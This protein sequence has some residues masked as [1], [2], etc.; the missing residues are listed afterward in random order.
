MGLRGKLVALFFIGFASTCSLGIAI[1]VRNLGSDFAAM[2]RNEAMRLND[3]LVRNFKAELEH[4]NE[5][6]TDWADWGGM[7]TFAQTLSPEFAADEVGTGALASAKL[8][9]VAIFDADHRRTFLR[10]A[11]GLADQESDKGLSRTLA[12]MQRLFETQGTTKT[13]SLHGADGEIYL[14]CWQYIHRSDGSGE[15]HGTLL[16]GRLL[17]E[18]ILRRMRNQS[19][20][21]FEI[22][23]VLPDADPARPGAAVGTVSAD[24]LV[25]GGP[26]KHMLTGRMLDAS[27]QPVFVFHIRLPS[28][29]ERSGRQITWRVILVVMIGALLSGV[30]L[31]LGV[32]YF[33]VRRLQLM[34]RQLRHVGAAGGWPEQIAT[35]PGGDEIATLGA[36]IN[37][38]LR[39]LREQGQAL[40]LLS[41][42]DPLTRLANRR[43]FDQ[44]LATG[45]GQCRRSALPL[46][47]LVLDVDHFKAYN[48]LYGHPAGDGVLVAIGQILRDAAS[49]PADLA[50]R[51]GGEEFAIL[52][53]DTTPEGAVRVATKIHEALA[54]QAIAHAGSSASEHVTVSIG[55]TQALHDE[56]TDEFVA[57]ADRATYG[58]KNAGRNRTCELGG[59][60]NAHGSASARE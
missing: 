32:Q 39:V 3:Q 38:M 33:L 60:E 15:P 29:I 10:A 28:D 48:D 13:C 7:Y 22:E 45:M 25:I 40:E 54:A 16:M 58:A 59:S 50:A 49:R 1:L 24:S 17:D 41:L 2:E 57:R 11:A 30:V 5:L 44:G 26:D 46:A 56:T 27:G 18:H 19:A 4:L 8:S 21:D 55:V 36:T 23:S 43:A 42:T 31:V 9:F 20:L 51:I 6:D 37:R 47:L 52:L 34:E 14:L 35:P 53:P 12:A